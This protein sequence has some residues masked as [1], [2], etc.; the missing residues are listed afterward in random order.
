MADHRLIENGLVRP[1]PK[2]CYTT[3]NMGSAAVYSRTSTSQAWMSLDIPIC[4]SSNRRA[5]ARSEE[6]TS[7]KYQHRGAR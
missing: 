3:I 2:M 4:N 7:S 5:T 1:M 6:T